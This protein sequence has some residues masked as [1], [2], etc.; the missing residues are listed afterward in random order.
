MNH[1]INA[2]EKTLEITF[3]GDVLS[4]NADQLR[5][6]IL[7][8]LETEPVKAAGWTTLKLDLTAAKMIDSVGLNLVVG[9]YKEA[10]KRNAKTSAFLRSA[11]IQR[12]FIFTRLDAHIQVVMVP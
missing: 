6:A 12:T 1:Q 8:L 10:K 2:A 5:T 11:N 9:L 4:T 3:P 7:A